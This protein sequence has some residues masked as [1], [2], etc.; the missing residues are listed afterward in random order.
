ASGCTLCAARLW[1]PP[2]WIAGGRARV[3][4]RALGRSGTARRLAAYRPLR[5]EPG[6][7]ELLD[8]MAARAVVLVPLLQADR[9][10]DW[11]PWPTGGPLGVDAIAG[12]DLVLAPA[13]AVSRRGVRL[14]PRGPP[15]RPA[16]S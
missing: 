11:T 1:L 3:L 2:V 8:G 9:D 16:P 6:S 7:V 13:L 5:T 4:A 10:L 12:V 14:P 15:C